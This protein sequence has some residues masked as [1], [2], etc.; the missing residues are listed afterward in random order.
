MNKT[1][2]TRLITL[3]AALG[4]ALSLTFT[5]AAPSMAAV[6]SNHTWANQQTLRGHHVRTPTRQHGRWA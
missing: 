4:A 3:A 2:I 6:T 1:I 5:A